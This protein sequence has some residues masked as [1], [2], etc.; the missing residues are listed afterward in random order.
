[1]IIDNNP[2]ALMLFRSLIVSLLDKSEK[3]IPSVT[4]GDL[5]D[6]HPLMHPLSL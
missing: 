3:I 1:M 2:A 4:P 5:K 6:D